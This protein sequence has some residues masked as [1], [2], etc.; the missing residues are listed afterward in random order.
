MANKSW[1][2]VSAGIFNPG[3]NKAKSEGPK[4]GDRP[5]STVA[6]PG[7]SKTSVI[8]KEGGT[9]LYSQQKAQKPLG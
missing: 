2:T 7:S 5:S 8:H 9:N 6:F 3:Y 1:P 4:A